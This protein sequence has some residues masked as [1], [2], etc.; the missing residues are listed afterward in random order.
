MAHYLPV[1]ETPPSHQSDTSFLVNPRCARLM[2][3][4]R[5]AT[6]PT[7]RT[8]ALLDLLERSMVNAKQV[9]K[10]RHVLG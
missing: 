5:R 8:V 9:V 2:R 10:Q 1:D 7:S 4:E 6:H 3:A